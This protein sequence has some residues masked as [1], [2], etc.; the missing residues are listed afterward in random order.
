MNLPLEGDEGFYNIVRADLGNVEETFL[1]HEKLCQHPPS[2]AFIH[3]VDKKSILDIACEKGEHGIVKRMLE[4]GASLSSHLDNN[5]F[6][7][8]VANNHRDV[9]MSL[10]DYFGV[11][12]IFNSIHFS[13]WS[14]LLDYPCLYTLDDDFLLKM[15]EFRFENPPRFRDSIT[16]WRKVRVHASG[17][18]TSALL[19]DLRIRTNMISINESAIRAAETNSIEIMKYLIELTP[20]PSLTASSFRQAACVA[21]HL[22]FIPILN[23]LLDLCPILTFYCLE[24]ESQEKQCRL[25]VCQYLLSRIYSPAAEPKEESQQRKVIQSFFSGKVISKTL[26]TIFME[27]GIIFIHHVHYELSEE[28]LEVDG[29][30]LL[31]LTG[32]TEN[33]PELL[34]R[35]A[36]KP[37]EDEMI[38]AR[39]CRVLAAAG[40]EIDPFA[41]NY[42]QGQ[43]RSGYDRRFVS[44]MLRLLFALFDFSIHNGW[45]DKCDLDRNNRFLYLFELGCHQLLSAHLFLTEGITIDLMECKNVRSRILQGLEK[46]GLAG[47]AVLNRVTGLKGLESLLYRA[48]FCPR[49]EEPIS[50][51]ALKVLIRSGWKHENMKNLTPQQVIPCIEM[52]AQNFTNAAVKDDEITREDCQ[53]L[54]PL[55]LKSTHPFL[56]G[57]MNFATARE[58]FIV[59]GAQDIA[60]TLQRKPNACS[61]S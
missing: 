12:N 48:C 46:S 31:L 45:F 52:L 6:V 3:K 36:T 50:I 42:Y 43:S 27:C 16:D 39:Y 8:A 14:E 25:D 59:K 24:N 34:F 1:A 5:A 44:F 28:L 9:C 23:L 60:D 56:R 2:V 33:S 18:S 10:I 54:L 35:R 21:T 29:D 19:Q 41:V 15:M 20:I 32:L 26:L 61:I 38:C 11:E 51:E 13:R 49:L 22:G 58:M 17:R 53:L 57:Q 47:V 7:L 30:V 4:L 55:I 37:H 40:L